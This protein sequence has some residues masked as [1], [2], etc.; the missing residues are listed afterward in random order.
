MQVGI[1]AVDAMAHKRVEDITEGAMEGIVAWKS[2]KYS[3]AVKLLDDERAGFLG[4]T[5][6]SNVYL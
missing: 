2:V 3:R 1:A 4:R 6:H 5:Q